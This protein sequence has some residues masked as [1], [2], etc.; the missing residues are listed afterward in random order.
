MNYMSFI[1]MLAE[2]ENWACQEMQGVVFNDKRLE[3]RLPTI[4]QTLFRHPT[5]SIPAACDSRKDIKA[6]YRFF[7]NDKV[8]FQ[9]IMAPHYK[10]TLT[11]IRHHPVVLFLNDISEI[12]LTDKTVAD[13]LGYIGDN[14]THG[15]FIH[16][17]LAVTPERLP[18]GVADY[19]TWLRTDISRTAQER[20][21]DPLETKETY[22][23]MLGYRN[24]CDLAKKAPSTTGV[25]VAD[26]GADIFEIYHEAH[27]RRHTAPAHFLIRAAYH[28]RRVDPAGGDD[29][30][31]DPPARHLKEQI[32]QRA[33][34]A[35][36]QFTL[37]ATAS[38]AKRPITQEVRAG[39][40]QLKVPHKQDKTIADAPVNAV[41]LTEPHPPTG[42]EPLVWLFLTSLPVETPE[43]C[44]AIIQ[45]Y[46]ARWEIECFFKVLKSG[47]QIEQ[48]Y[49]Q[50]DA[51][52]MNAL[53]I[54]TII[55][56]RLLYCTRLG[57][58]CPDLPCTVL[59]TEAEWRALYSI[60]EQEAPPTAPA[61][62]PTLQTMTHWIAQCGGFL[63]R[64]GDGEP[65]IKTMWNGMRRLADFAIAYKTFGPKKDQTSPEK[66]RPKDENKSMDSFVDVST[67][68]RC[69]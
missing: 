29:S 4:L 38:H 56:W 27:L 39:Q 43:Q 3:D 34:L 63:G 58:A 14:K 48:L 21:H 9:E 59:Y 61:Q 35:T 20:K 47:C 42:Q 16:P 26:R 6:T 1:P 7:D 46:L 30:A 18:L 25:Y 22:C 11:R 45:Y 67:S 64:P 24:T 41:L 8:S 17:L 36:V 60:M 5:E 13:Q 31:T 2:D 44:E 32:A 49:L 62:P 54:Y 55:A 12:N 23:W 53:A 69:G 33:P 15:L 66:S 10:Q 37:Q 52:F 65:G 19:Y 50:T 57:R 28:D 51:R 68:K 40:I